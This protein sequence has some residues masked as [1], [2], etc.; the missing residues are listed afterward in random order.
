MGRLTLKYSNV[1][2][3]ASG[4]ITQNLSP[5]NG[6]KWIVLMAHLKLSTS[7]T[8]G[9][10]NAGLYHLNGM[11]GIG[12]AE[13]LNTNDQTSEGVNFYSS[14]DGGVSTSVTPDIPNPVWGAYP[15]II[16]DSYNVLQ[17]NANVISGD[18]L[19]YIIYVEELI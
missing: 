16:V 6:Y 19:Y 5:P 15:G 12:V 13:L 9:T 14:F 18:S 17:I 2:V 8:S 10:R 1:D 11:D 3:E 7:T 4:L